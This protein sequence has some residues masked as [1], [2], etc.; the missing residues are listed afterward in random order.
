MM[1]GGS[2]GQLLMPLTCFLVILLK[3]RDTFGA[4]VVLFGGVT[5]SEVADYHDW[6]FILRK[7]GWLRYDRAL[8]HLTN[9][10]G[11]LLMLISFVWGGYILF[12]QYKNLGRLLS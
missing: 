2:L 4:S 11:I 1:L 8:A 5:G 6:E 9:T 3:T 10:V 12:K 7:L